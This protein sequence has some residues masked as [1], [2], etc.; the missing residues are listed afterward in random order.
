M[1]GK[2]LIILF[3]AKM[4][5]EIEKKQY[6]IFITALKRAGFSMLQKSVYIKHA[7]DTMPIKTHFNHVSA[8]IPKSISAICFSFSETA[9]LSGSFINCSPPILLKNKTI[10]CI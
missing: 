6:T 2:V 10:I 5:T 8:F 9:F 3:D 7:I 1:I 4:K